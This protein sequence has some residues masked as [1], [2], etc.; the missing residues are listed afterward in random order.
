MLV[1]MCLSF[2]CLLEVGFEHGVQW[3]VNRPVVPRV[4]PRS[5]NIIPDPQERHVILI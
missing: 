5:A 2:S 3:V 4:P 1:F